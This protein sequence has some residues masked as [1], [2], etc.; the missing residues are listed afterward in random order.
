MVMGLVL[1]ASS[2]I[3]ARE[4]KEVSITSA[5][6]QKLALAAARRAGNKNME[7]VS[8]PTKPVTWAEIVQQ[9]PTYNDRE[10][11]QCERA[12]RRMR[13]HRVWIV[14]LRDKLPRGTVVQYGSLRVLVDDHGRVVTMFVVK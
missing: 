6:A 2:E 13:H 4:S 1:F 10:C 12:R 14:V 11:S 8:A 5:Q 7:V 3:H 9:Y